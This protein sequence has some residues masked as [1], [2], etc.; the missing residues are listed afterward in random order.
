MAFVKSTKYRHKTFTLPNMIRTI[1]PQRNAKSK[2]LRH[3]KGGRGKSSASLS[4]F[5]S[6]RRLGYIGRSCGLRKPALQGGHFLPAGGHQGGPFLRGAGNEDVQEVGGTVGLPEGLGE[7]GVPRLGVGGGGVLLPPDLQAVEVPAQHPE[8]TLLGLTVRA[9]RRFPPLGGRA[10]P[11]GRLGVIA[12]AKVRRQGL[13]VEQG[14]DKVGGV[15][16]I[17]P[18]AETV[19][20]LVQL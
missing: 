15:P 7:Q 5:R 19:I 4:M 3:G 14:G 20:P 9:R 6:S 13:Q 8:G 1:Y 17:R 12:K 11:G 2:L 18:T 16:S 10:G